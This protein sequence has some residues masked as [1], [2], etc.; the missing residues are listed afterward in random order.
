[1]NPV[2]PLAGSSPPPHDW[3]AEYLV[4]A[5]TLIAAAIYFGFKGRK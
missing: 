3:E 4:V 5:L 1:M 2:I